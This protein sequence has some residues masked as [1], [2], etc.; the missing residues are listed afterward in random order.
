MRSDQNRPAGEP[1]P[2]PASRTVRERL[3]RRATRNMEPAP[4]EMPPPPWGTASRWQPPYPPASPPPPPPWGYPAYPGYPTYPYPVYPPAQYPPPP[5]PQRPPPVAAPGYPAYP[6]YP[7]YPY[8]VYPPA[9]YPPPPQPQWPPPVAAPGYPPPAWPALG[10][11]PPAY[12]QQWAPPLAPPWAYPQFQQPPYVAEPLPPSSQHQATP[13]RPL[14]S[15]AGRAAPRLYAAGWI[16]SL[17]GAAALIALVAGASA[18]ATSGIPRPIRIGAGFGSIVAIL[19]GLVAAAVAQ[20]RQRRADG[21]QDYFGPSPLLSTGVVLALSMASWVLVSGVVEWL[22]ITIATSVEL[23][24]MLLVNLACYVGVAHWLGVRTGALTWRDMVWPQRLAKTRDELLTE[25]WGSFWR[26]RQSRLRSTLGDIGIG[27]GLAVPGMIGSAVLAM[28]LI[29]I[30]GLEDAPV[31]QDSVV[32][33]TGWDIWIALVAMAVVAPIGEEIFFRGM[34]TNA[35]ARSLTRQSA[36]LRG[37]FLFASIHL[38]NNALDPSQMDLTIRL[39]ILAVAARLPV[40]WL[41]SWVYTSRRSIVA[42]IAL[43]GAYNG[44]L[45]LLAW[46]AAQQQY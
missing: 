18:G 22:G 13:R 1:A 43:H 37:T 14:V 23:L 27:F 8:P 11:P 12:P 32:I 29:S 3:A 7:Y 40:A 2:T 16:L 15:L 24:L 10:Y 46:W 41:L 6:G 36:L 28:V 9:Q 38:L 35:W 33:T 44:S 45:V 21:W 5:Q 4:P 30:L 25:S 39:A 20:S 19:A 31:S 42:S 26:P 34:I 17:V